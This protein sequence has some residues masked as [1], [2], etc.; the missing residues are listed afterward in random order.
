[1]GGGG[2]AFEAV[3][4][5]AAERRAVGEK[6]R[7]DGD[8]RGRRK[9]VPARGQVQQNGT[10][11]SLEDGGMPSCHVPGA[12]PTHGYAVTDCTGNTAG[13]MGRSP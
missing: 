8:E 10:E 3:T 11:V 7:V 12:E 1:M 4:V 13:G 6:D 5:G 2:T 9:D